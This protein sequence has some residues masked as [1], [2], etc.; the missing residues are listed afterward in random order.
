MW[1]ILRSF[2]KTC[3]GCCM[4]DEHLSMCAKFC[5]KSASSLSLLELATES[6]EHIFVPR[7][8]WMELSC[9]YELY[10]SPWTVQ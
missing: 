6:F 7:N 1:Y 5:S 8:D 9:L 4:S 10:D 2:E 3:V